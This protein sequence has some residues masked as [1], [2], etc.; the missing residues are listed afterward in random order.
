MNDWEKPNETSLSKKE[1][2]RSLRYGRSYIFM[3]TYVFG[4]YRNMSYIYV[5]RNMCFIYIYIYIYIQTFCSRISFSSWVSMASNLKIAKVKINL[6]TD[7]NMLL[8]LEKGTRGGI[9][10]SI[11]DMQKL[12]NK[13]KIMIKM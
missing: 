3:L 5:F 7:I 13:R 8:M 10:H 12:T 1:G 6:L 11:Y 4:N 2:L 9:C